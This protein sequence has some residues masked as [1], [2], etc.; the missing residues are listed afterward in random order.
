MRYLITLLLIAVTIVLYAQDRDGNRM[1]KDIEVAEKVIAASLETSY[2]KEGLRFS[3]EGSY[4]DGY[5]VLFT[6]RQTYSP[7]VW[8]GN[9]NGQL[10]RLYQSDRAPRAITPQADVRPFETAA[11]INL[12]SMAFDMGQFKKAVADYLVDYGYLLPKLTAGEKICLKLTGN[13]TRTYSDLLTTNFTIAVPGG[14]PNQTLTAVV[15]RAD[16]ADQQ[17][18]KITRNQLESK[19]LFSEDKGEDNKPDKESEMVI[20]IFQR[21]YQPDLSQTY[22]LNGGGNY[23]RIDGMGRIFTLGFAHRKVSPYGVLFDRMNADQQARWGLSSDVVVNGTSVRIRPR[24]QNAPEDDEPKE[25]KVNDQSFADFLEGFKENIIEYGGTLKSLAADEM[26]T[27]RLNITTCD[28][29]EKVPEK[30]EISVKQPVLEGY[31][32]G[33]LTIE[34]ALAQLKVVEN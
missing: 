18:G 1:K 13:Y 31:R 7:V 26:V 27:F 24:G 8:G 32:K 14:A 28:E 34:Q 12:D 5:G 10:D 6:L 30:V 22:R 21:L 4:L 15:G 16:I 20:S 19:I 3:V 29:C 11:V 2:D 33:T 25:E 23:E 17:A 9:I